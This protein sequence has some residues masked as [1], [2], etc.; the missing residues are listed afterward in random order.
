MSAEHQSTTE[1]D[2]INQAALLPDSKAVYQQM[3]TSEKGLAK[4]AVQA[5]QAK[6]GK[7]IL[8]K[9]KGG[10]TLAAIFKQLYQYHGLAAVDCRDNCLLC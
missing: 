1:Q 4:Q 9:S 7:N 3:A 8:Q 6:Y 10:P 2:E 5:R